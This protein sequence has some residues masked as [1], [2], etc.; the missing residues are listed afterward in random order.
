MRSC[1]P[2]T[3]LAVT[4]AVDNGHEKAL[5]GREGQMET[6]SSAERNTQGVTA[7][8]YTGTTEVL[9]LVFFPFCLVE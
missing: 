8:Y 9:E 7:A 1:D 6:L 3:H 2:F 4:V 5:R